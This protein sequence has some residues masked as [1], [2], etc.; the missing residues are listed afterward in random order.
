MVVGMLTAKSCMIENC[1]E[2][3]KGSDLMGGTAVNM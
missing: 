3:C 1:K 2:I